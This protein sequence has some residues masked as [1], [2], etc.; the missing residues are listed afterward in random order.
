MRYGDGKN[1]V[2]TCENDVARVPPQVLKV[3][4]VISAKAR[5]HLRINACT[6]L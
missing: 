1:V 2:K 6:A 5:Q 4:P 3:L